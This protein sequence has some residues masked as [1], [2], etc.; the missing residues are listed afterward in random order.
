MPTTAHSADQAV[1][2]LR[3]FISKGEYGLD[4]VPTLVK[5][6][7]GKEYWRERVVQASGAVAHFDDFGR[8]IVYPPPDG[9]GTDLKT[10]LRMCKR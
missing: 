5:E 3:E 4:A 8:F 7:I 6:I 1:D 2:D 10:L 9:V